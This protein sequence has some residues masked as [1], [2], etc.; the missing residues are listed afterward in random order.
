MISLFFTQPEDKPL[1]SARVVEGFAPQVPERKNG[2]EVGVPVLPRPAVVDLV[3]SGT[4]ENSPEKGRVTEENVGVPEIG[5]KGVPD[6]TQ[7]LHSEEL[8]QLKSHS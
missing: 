1:V 5:A 2:S 8:P 7:S 3:G 4:E 6:E